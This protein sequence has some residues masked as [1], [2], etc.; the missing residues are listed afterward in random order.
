MAVNLVNNIRLVYV[1]VSVLLLEAVTF[2]ARGF[3]P[4]SKLA[5]KKDT[6]WTT[7]SFMLVQLLMIF[8]CVFEVVLFDVPVTTFNNAGL[9]LVGFVLIITYLSH[10]ELGEQF[11]PK[12]EVKKRHKLVDT[13][14]YSLIRHP[15]YLASLLFMIALPMSASAYF[16]FL[17]AIPFIVVLWFRIKYEEDV[18]SMGLRGY[19]AYMK[20]T[21]MLIPYLL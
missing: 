11:S 5:E 6:H 10:K 21:K 1:I 13:G 9:A 4:K 19:K 18:L 8:S 2:I 17:W 16:A 20:R 3:V 12:I 15:M 14:I 7:L